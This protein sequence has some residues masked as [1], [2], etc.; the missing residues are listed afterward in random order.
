M[1]LGSPYLVQKGSLT[2]VQSH[3]EH[4]ESTSVEAVF[5]DDWKEEAESIVRNCVETFGRL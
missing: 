3:Y 1:I 2:N 5:D 4:L